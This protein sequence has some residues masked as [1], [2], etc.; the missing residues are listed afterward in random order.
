MT[1]GSQ[2]PWWTLARLAAR[3]VAST[4]RKRAAPPATAQT[5]QRQRNRATVKNRIVV[6]TNVAL[7]A[8]P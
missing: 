4:D 3:N 2:P 5:G 6:I 8:T 1:S 7:T